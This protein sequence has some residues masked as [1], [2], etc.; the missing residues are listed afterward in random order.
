MV[1][2]FDSQAT[3][4]TNIEAVLK[5]VAAGDISVE[6]GAQFISGIEK[7]AKV[8][9]AEVT[10]DSSVPRMPWRSPIPTVEARASLQLSEA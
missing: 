7:L 6:T 10:E 2:R 4:A 3:P 5:A 8:K 1:F 9:V